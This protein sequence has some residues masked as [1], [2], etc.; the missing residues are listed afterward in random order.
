MAEDLSNLWR[1][2]SHSEEES[3]AV[4]VKCPLIFGGKTHNSAQAS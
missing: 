3:L 1:I 2:F 4:E